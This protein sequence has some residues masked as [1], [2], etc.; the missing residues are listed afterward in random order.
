MNK[1]HKLYKVTVHYE[2]EIEAS[3]KKEAISGAFEE[4]DE[5]SNRPLSLILQEDHTKAEIIKNNTS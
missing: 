1:P 4:L 3:T 5:Q 2:T